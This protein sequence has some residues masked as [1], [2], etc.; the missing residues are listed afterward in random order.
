MVQTRAWTLAP[1]EEELQYPVG[2]EPIVLDICEYQGNLV[3]GGEMSPIGLGLDLI[4]YDGTQWS[5]VGGGL[6]GSIGAVSALEVYQ[7]ELYVG[8]GMYVG[9][10][11][12]GH[13]L[14]RWNGSQWRDVGGSMRDIY[15]TTQ[16]N[17]SANSFMLHEEK[18]YVG[19]SFGYAGD[20]EASKFAI[21]DGNRW[22]STADSLSGRVES[23][24][25][26]HDTL[27]VTCWD[28]LHGEPANYIAKW[29]GGSLEQVCGSGVGISELPDPGSKIIIGP[30]LNGQRMIQGLPDG[31]Y[32]LTIHDAMGKVIG[33]QQVLS[34][35]GKGHMQQP[36]LAVGLYI[37]RIQGMAFGGTARFVAEQ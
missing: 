15:G 20:V 30:V 13:G 12:P 19:G 29:T 27:Y 10:G 34:N 18:L 28:S 25:Y 26:Y 9:A 23:M 17:A 36:P 3:V 2:N 37:V 6:A 35:D 33:T 11:S 7:G 22:C 21:W 32:D 24:A 5:N 31:Q 8:G 1:V 16:Y 14:V 4:Q